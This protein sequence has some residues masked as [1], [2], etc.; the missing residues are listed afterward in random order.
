VL[1]SGDHIFVVALDVLRSA[2][3]EALVVSRRDALTRG[4]R[5]RPMAATDLD[6]AGAA[7]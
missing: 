3:V 7:A 2:D 5:V 4:L 1:G 6:V